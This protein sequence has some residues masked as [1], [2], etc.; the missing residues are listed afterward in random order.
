MYLYESFCADRRTTADVV[1]F[2]FFQFPSEKY[3]TGKNFYL[4]ILQNE[5]SQL[6]ANHNCI[7]DLHLEGTK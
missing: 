1:T 2:L 6:S 7:I 5:N 3:F 4:F